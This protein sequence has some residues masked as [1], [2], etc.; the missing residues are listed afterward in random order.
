[1][2]PSRRPE[3][4]RTRKNA[5]FPP[6]LREK[7][8]L[9]KKLPVIIQTSYD[10]NGSEKANGRAGKAHFIFTLNVHLNPLSTNFVVVLNLLTT[11][12]NVTVGNSLGPI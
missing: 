6:I 4:A 9:I 11:N 8:Y 10:G 3:E 12:A 7:R 5:T 1:M 2:N